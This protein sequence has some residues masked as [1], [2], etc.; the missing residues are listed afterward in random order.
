MTKRAVA[1]AGGG[2]GDSLPAAIV[3]LLRAL[4]CDFV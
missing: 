1:G 3:L 2:N 4:V